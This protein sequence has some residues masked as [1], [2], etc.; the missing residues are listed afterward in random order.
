MKKNMGSYDKSVRLGISIVL[1]IL[2]YKQVLPGVT[3]IIALVLALLLAITSLIGLCPLYS[4]FGI[5][6][7]KK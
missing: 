1:I 5:K 3:G 6:T 2:Y 4:I 7:T